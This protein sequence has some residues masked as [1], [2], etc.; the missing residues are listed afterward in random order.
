M[1]IITKISTINIHLSSTKRFANFWYL[2]KRKKFFSKRDNQRTSLYECIVNTLL[3][4]NLAWS[5][6]LLFFN[7]SLIFVCQYKICFFDVP[8][9]CAYPALETTGI[10]K[11][12]VVRDCSYKLG[13]VRG[14][15]VHN[16]RTR[17]RESVNTCSNSFAIHFHSYF[18]SKFQFQTI[19]SLSTHNGPLWPFIKLVN[20]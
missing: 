16:T 6:Y 11:A 5:Q 3:F 13:F 2:S 1:L 4:T 20:S 7:S 14:T 18:T 17:H 10:N 9:G 12:C 8:L 15:N 19:H